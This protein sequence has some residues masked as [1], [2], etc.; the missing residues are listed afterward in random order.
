MSGEQDHF[1]FLII[2]SGFGGSVSALRLAEK[3]YSVAILE[4]GRRFEDK[5]FPTTN[6]NIFKSLWAPCL[7][8][9]GMLKIN[10]LSDVMIL[11]YAGVGGGSLGYANILLEPPDRF[12]E[13]RQWA[14]M[15][16]WKDA[17]APHYRTAKKMLGVTRV[18]DLSPADKVMQKVADRLGC[19]DTFELQQ[20]GVYF[21]EAEVTAA[22]PYFGGRGPDRTGCNLCGGCMVGCRHNAKNSLPKNYLYLAE[23]LGV[24]IFPD[25]RA[26]LIHEE[27]AGGYRVETNRP[28][29]WMGGRPRVFS[30]NN[31]VLSAGVLGTLRLLMECR[32]SGTLDRLSPM[33][34]A[35]VRTNSETLSGAT[36]RSGQVDYSRG[37]AITSS[38]YPDSVTHI[39]PVRY[40]HGSD[41][42]CLVAT[43]FTEQAG[44]VLRPLKWL[45]NV[46]RHPLL[47]LRTLNPFGWARKT[48]ILLVMQTLD[49]S[50]R[51]RLGN[52]RWWPF[53]RAL[54]SEREDDRPKV[55][56][57]IP[58][59]QKATRILAEEI[60]GFAQNAI[61]EVLLNIGT[62]AHILGGCAIGPDPATG[63]ID[64]HNQV[65]GYKGMYIVD[66]SMIP[67]NLGVNPSLT[68]TAMAEHAMSHIPPKAETALPDHP[69]IDKD[70]H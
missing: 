50:V 17:L 70:R 2:G 18:K 16:D 35:R 49:N 27:P 46:I 28:T 7:R 39:E 48:V 55:P 54:V 33:L 44:P 61:N 59:A 21:G 56:V 11:G 22:D 32:Q 68:I 12:F 4:A 67:A 31:L 25:T 58:V 36:A 6:W 62:T 53:G 13:N 65:Y 37:V 52:R 57:C 34:G 20:V 3:G 45:W 23:K 30:G 47:F 9:F 29:A 64:G 41:L 15:Q 42:L 38:I 69:Q 19:A 66:G 10:F 1:D 5:D 51:V 26:T 43:L 8:C 40:P 24:R 60:D 63:V 14:G